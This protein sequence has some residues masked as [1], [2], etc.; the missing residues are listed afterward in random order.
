MQFVI[1][2]SNPHLEPRK[3]SHI[4]EVRKRSLLSN[5]QRMAVKLYVVFYNTPARNQPSLKGPTV[6]DYHVM[7]A[8]RVEPLS[9]RGRGC[10]LVK[11]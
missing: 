8:R 7:A 3:T 5:Y 6:V 4:A 10:F 11:V 1:S 2:R 9:C